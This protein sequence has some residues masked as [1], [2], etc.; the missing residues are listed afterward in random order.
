MPRQRTVFSS[1][2]EVSHEWAKQFAGGIDSD[3]HGRAGNV[4]FEGATIYSYGSHFPIARILRVPSERQRKRDPDAIPVVLF[5]SDDWSP[6]TAQHKTIVRCAL[7]AVRIVE[8]PM[9]SGTPLTTSLRDWSG[10][11]DASFGRW[12]LDILADERAALIE[13][14]RKAAQN[15]R[16]HNPDRYPNAIS[17][18]DSIRA[19]HAALCKTFRVRRKPL[20]KL[21]V[22]DLI[23]PD[24][25]RTLREQQANRRRSAE[26][27]AETRRRR[28]RERWEARFEAYRLERERRET[29]LD[30]SRPYLSP[31][32]LAAEKRRAE[33]R[34]LLKFRDGLAGSTNASLRLVCGSSCYSEPTLL[35]VSEDGRTIRTNRYASIPFRLLPGLL[36]RLELIRDAGRIPD[37]LSRSVGEFRLD[38]LDC[39]RSGD[40]G[41][42]WEHDASL[43]IGCHKIT[44]AEIDRFARER[45]TRNALIAQRFRAERYASP[46]KIERVAAS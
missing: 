3:R 37:N 17:R 32:D 33:S 6:S 25:F 20:A 19:A 8:L 21:H 9:G 36:R 7:P 42:N 24:R 26:T 31:E 18:L 11:A 22:A 45:R 2:E 5:N 30:P 44:L 34:L 15:K 27:A 46:Q 28:D 13:N 23:D 29:G 10:P 12:V 35:A 4:Y 39:I 1:R 41:F 40:S 43:R 14:E 38:A 16:Y